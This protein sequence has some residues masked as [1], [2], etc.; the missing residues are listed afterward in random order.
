MTSPTALVLPVEE[1]CAAA[2]AHGALAI[3]DGAHAPGQVAVELDALGA[4]AYAGNCHKWLCAP[5]GAGFLW[6]RPEE[7]SR[8]AVA[9]STRKLLRGLI[10]PQLPLPL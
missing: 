7:V 9:S 4:D 6:A 5:K 10:T 1:I 2:R 8:L 3:V